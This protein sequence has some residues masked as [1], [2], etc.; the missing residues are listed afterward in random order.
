MSSYT[1]LDYS[2]L[3]LKKTQKNVFSSMITTNEGQEFIF[4]NYVYENNPNFEKKYQIPSGYNKIYTLKRGNIIIN[5][6]FEKN[7]N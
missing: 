5:E 1:P 2:K 6:I 3:I 7:L 4:S